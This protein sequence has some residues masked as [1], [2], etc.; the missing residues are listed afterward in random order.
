MISYKNKYPEFVSI[1]E[2]VLKDNPLQRKKI[3]SFLEKQDLSYWT[4][5]EELSNSL[6]QYF[7][8]S[9]HN[10]LDVVKAYNK[11]CMEI[12]REQIR[13]KKTGYYLCNSSQIVETEVY[14]DK[15]KMRNYIIGL[16]L[17]Y[18]FWPNHYAILDFFQKEL[19]Q[20]DTSR[21]LEIGAGH[22]LFTAQVLKKFNNAEINIIDIS[23]E[24]LQIAKEILCAFN[25]PTDNI[26]FM[27][28][29]FLKTGDGI[30]KF[31]FIIMGEVLEHVEDAPGF[32][33]K[34][35]ELLDKDG[36]IFMSTCVNSPAIDHIYHFK[37]I[38]EIRNL[39]RSIGLSI[40]DEIVLPVEDIPEEKWEKDLVA[41]NYAAILTLN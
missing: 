15:D 35:K 41:I 6:N 5:A 9:G 34:A 18:L 31:D 17:S 8:A 11:T 22:G 12:L 38:D 27:L 21:C 19:N 3:S 33:L 23:N 36:K 10:K 20:V 24:S 32:L 37:T 16:L 30:A 13:F 1:I 40:S 26:H 25:L 39:I 2:L 4:F 29:D 14:S 7:L 28:Q